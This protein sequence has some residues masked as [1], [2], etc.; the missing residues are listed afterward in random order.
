MTEWI[1]LRNNERTR[2][3]LSAIGPSSILSLLNYN[4]TYHGGRYRCVGQM[5]RYSD[6]IESQDF[7]VKSKCNTVVN[8]LIF[9][10]S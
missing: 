10:C 2:S 3:K 6:T 1:V 7:T 9:L 8:R 5:Q 4:P